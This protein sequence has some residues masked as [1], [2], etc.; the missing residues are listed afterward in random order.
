MLLFLLTNRLNQIVNI[1]TT[2]G[3]ILDIIQKLLNM[4]LNIV[5]IDYNTSG[6]IRIGLQ[7]FYNWNKR[8][9]LGINMYT[10][11]NSFSETIEFS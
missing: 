6:T 9:N 4:V 7:L 11:N 1:I 3:A 2:I 10:I 5:Q 8:L